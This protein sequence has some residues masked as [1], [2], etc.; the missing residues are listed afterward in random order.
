LG[1]IHCCYLPIDLAAFIAELADRSP[2][3]KEQAQAAIKEA[4]RRWLSSHPPTRVRIEAARSLN[5]PGSFH[6]PIPS[7]ALFSEFQKISEN[8]TTLIY[9]A[10]FGR[11]FSADAVRP[12]REAVDQYID[13]T[14]SQRKIR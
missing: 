10:H 2:R 12:T 9:Q 7:T 8:L 13:I 14:A 3:V 4:K 5:L 1:S 6:S 11:L